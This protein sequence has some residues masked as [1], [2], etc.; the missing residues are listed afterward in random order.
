MSS[1]SCSCISLQSTTCLSSNDQVLFESSKGKLSPAT[2]TLHPDVVHR[3]EQLVADRRHFHR[4]P[5]LSFQE[6]ETARYIVKRLKEIGVD[7]VFEQV[8]KTGVVGIIRGRRSPV[9]PCSSPSSSSSSSSPSTSQIRCECIA[10]RA[11]MDALPLAEV[12]TPMNTDYISQNANCMHACG[13]DGHMA[14]LLCAAAVLCEKR[15]LFSGVIKLIFQ[16]AEEGFSGARAMIKDGVLDDKQGPRVDEIYGIHLWNYL[17]V[18]YVGVRGGAVM[19]ASDHFEIVVKGVGGHG[20]VPDIACDAIVATAHLIQQLQTIV[21]RNVSP[22]EPAVVTVGTVNG[23][24]AYNIIADNV[25]LTG[26]VRTM[27]GDVRTLI[28]RRMHELCDGLAISFPGIHADLHY[29]PGYPCTNNADHHAVE[30]VRTACHKVVDAAH[31]VQEGIVTMGAEDFSYYMLERPGCFFFVG[32]R[33]THDTQDRPH[34]KST[35]DI[36]ETALQVSASAFVRIVED[37]LLFGA[38]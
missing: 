2:F 18:G 34:H 7:E 27:N 9:A 5:E 20:A 29:N 35:F 21:S 15:A 1:S 13:H 16:P 3:A 6:V 38:D 4:Y 12:A 17:P 36:H 19:A 14:S 28:I 24:Y 37:R 32:S 33:P 22:L 23:G 31:V 30:H 8:G 11:D 25:K 26:T 10:L